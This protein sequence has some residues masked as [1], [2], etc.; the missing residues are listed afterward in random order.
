MIGNVKVIS[1]KKIWSVMVVK[2]EEAVHKSQEFFKTRSDARA[3]KRLINNFSNMGKAQI[4][5]TTEITFADGLVIFS[6]EK[7]R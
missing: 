4:Y 6:M 2:D 5:R 3:Y 1:I 7:V